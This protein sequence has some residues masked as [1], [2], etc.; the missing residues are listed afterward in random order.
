[1]DHIPSTLA[2]QFHLDADEPFTPELAHEVASLIASD[3][4]EGGFHIPSKL[5]LGQHWLRHAGDYPT[6]QVRL[7]HRSVV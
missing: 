4:V 2:W 1:M 3:P 7:I 5:M 6:Y